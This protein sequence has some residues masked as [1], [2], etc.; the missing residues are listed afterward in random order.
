LTGTARALRDICE[1]VSSGG[2]P[3]RK[4]RGFFASEGGHLWVKSQEFN[5]G[6]IWETG[7][8]ISDA[9]LAASSAKYY[10]PHT[11]LVAM[12]GATV[13]KL[14]I[15]R[16]AATVNQAI[17]A[18]RVDPMVAD[19]LYVFYALLETRG[20]LT[21]QATG[22]AQQNLNQDLIRNFE[23]P[24]PPLETQ[25]RIAGVLSVYDD[26][27][28]NNTRRLQILEEMT[29]AIYREW[30]VEFRFPGHG[31]VPLV[32]SELGPEP[33]GWTVARMY[34]VCDVIDCL[35]SKKPLEREE[36]SGTLLQLSNIA[37]RGV[38][39][40]STR[41]LVSPD[42][43]RLWTSRI[44]VGEGD[45]V[46]TNVGRVGAV[47]QVPVGVNAALGRNMTAVRPR[48]GLMTPTY[49]LEYLLSPHMAAEKARKGDIGTIMDALNVKG[50]IRLNVPVP[51]EGLLRKFESVT[52]PMRRLVEVLVIEAGNL[53][54]TR[55]FLLRRLV[56]GQ[57]DVSGLD[58]DPSGLVA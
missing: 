20:A 11:V 3:S 48:P 16:A 52:R 10:P 24:L 40:L 33:A 22:A 45:C 46:I 6:F 25:R 18:L 35:H 53:R 51:P 32:N 31:D 15:L 30:F 36:G 58:I 2:T 43:Y 44:E 54:R 42:D 56:S 47:A 27:I 12:Y 38:L 50:I 4:N 19:Y 5:D 14:A 7:E 1:Q 34:E 29:Q 28:E 39:D 26:L 37:E 41:Y 21:A 55:D 13:G 17:C 9:G 57:V 8:H 49:L 23:I